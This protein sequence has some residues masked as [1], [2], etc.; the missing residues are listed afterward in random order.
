MV[1]FYVNVKLKAGYEAK[2][3]EIL[4]EIVPASRK[5]KGCIS[6]ECGVVA[7]SKSE[8]C[9]MESWENLESQKEHMKSA[10]MVK[11]AAALEACKES[12]EV[13]IINFVSTKE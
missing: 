4:K 1:G 2:F 3:E 8:Y 7:G 5:D 13:K 10:H 11:N 6:Y 9:F 12:Q